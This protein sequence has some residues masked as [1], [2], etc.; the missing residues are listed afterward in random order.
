MKVT[1]KFIL[2]LL[3]IYPLILMAETFKINGQEIV[4]HRDDSKALTISLDCKHSDCLALANLEKL[5][6]K[7]INQKIVFNSD[8]NPGALICEKALAGEVVIGIN[9]YGE[10]SFCRFSDGSMID[11][12]S[13]H[14][15]S[16]KK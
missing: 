7:K 14:Y 9:T 4:F 10:N 13:L 15:W 16:L 12:S 6:S 8:S 5:K 3:L 1:N 11:N 2:L